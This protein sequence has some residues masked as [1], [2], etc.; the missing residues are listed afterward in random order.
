MKIAVVAD[1][2]RV[3]QAPDSTSGQ[4]IVTDEY[5]IGRDGKA[6]PLVKQD[7]DKANGHVSQMG[8]VTER[9]SNDLLRRRN[10][11]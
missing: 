7:Q 9:P 3:K 6:W 1:H 8:Q 10:P 11:P 2:I 4:V 5:V